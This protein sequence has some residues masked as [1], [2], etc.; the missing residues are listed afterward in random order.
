MIRSLVREGTSKVSEFDMQGLANMLWAL[1][2]M[3]VKDTALLE[4]SAAAVARLA[5]S[6][7]T[8]SM[9]SIPSQSIAQSIANILWAYAKVSFRS[10]PL[11][12]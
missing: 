9:G 4:A 6:H 7:C 8:G 5:D 12:S 3:L 10:Q 2:A 11:L 1:G